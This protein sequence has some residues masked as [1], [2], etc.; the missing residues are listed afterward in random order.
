V[1]KLILLT[2]LVLLAAALSA[3]THALWTGSA[4]TNW[5]NPANWFSNVV[6]TNTSMVNIQADL[7]NYPVISQGPAQCRSL[8]VQNGGQLSLDGANLSVTTTMTVKGN[9]TITSANQIDV[10]GNLTWDDGATVTISHSG[11]VIAARQNVTFLPGS[12][13]KFG[14]GTLR[15]FTST[16]QYK[17]LKNQSAN[18]EF[19]DL[20]MDVRSPAKAVFSS[21]STH[22]FVVNHNFY[23]GTP[24]DSTAECIFWYEGNMILKNDFVSYN[25]ERGVDW[26]Y[27]TLVMEGE[28]DQFIHPTGV[29]GL[30]NLCIRSGGTVEV[31][32]DLIC[33]GNLSI[34]SGVLS[35]GSSTLS[36]WGNWTNYAGFDHFDAGSSTVRFVKHDDSQHHYGN[37]HF[38]VLEIDKAL[39]AFLIYNGGEVIC[40]EY[41]VVRGAVA[42]MDG[43]FTALSLANNGLAGGWYCY[44]NGTIN[45]Y[46]TAPGAWIDLLGYIYMAGGTMNIYGG[47]TPSYWPYAEGA[48]VQIHGGVLD[49]KTQ[50]IHLYSGAY[51][52]T[53][54]TDITG[55]TIRMAGDFTGYHS[56]FSASGATIELYGTEEAQ[57]NILEPMMLPTLKINKT[58]WG[59]RK[60]DLLSD[61]DCENLIVQAGTLGI[62]EQ[63]LT[64][65]NDLTC[66]GNISMGNAGSNGTI[67]VEGNMNFLSGSS[68]QFTSGSAIGRGDFLVENGAIIVFHEGMILHLQG[69]GTHYITVQEDL[70]GFQNLHLG[71]PNRNAH[72]LVSNESTHD[73]FVWGDLN[74]FGTSSLGFEENATQPVKVS[75]TMNMFGGTLNVG[76]SKVIVEGK[77]QFLATSSINI[78]HNGE[79]IFNYHDIP[80]QIEFRG[81]VTIDGGTLRLANSSLYIMENC[82]FNMNSGYVI[83]DGVNAQYAGSFQPTGGTVIMDDNYGNGN[84]GISVINGNWLPN[85]VVD[86]SIGIWLIDDLEVKG[87]IDVN[88]GW[89]E[90]NGLILT[91]RGDLNV[92]NGGL[93]KLEPGTTIDF[94]GSPHSK[95]RIHSGGRL[96]SLGTDAQRITI[97]NSVDWMEYSVLDGG[98][99]AAEYTD[100]RHATMDGFYVH[101]GAIVDEEH[102][103]HNCAFEYSMGLE[104]SCLLRIENDQILTVKNAE[105]NRWPNANNVRKSENQ[106]IVH[107]IDATGYSH[108]EQYEKDPHDR[109]FWSPCLDPDVPDLVILKAEYI[110]QA[111]TEG[112]EVLCV[113]TFS[114]I[115]GA[116]VIDPFYIDLYHNRQTP[117]V[118]GNVGNAFYQI[119]EVPAYSTEQV[120]F[121]VTGYGTGTWNSYVQIDTD[122]DAFESNDYNN[123][124]GPFQMIWLP[125]S[126][127]PVTNLRVNKTQAG[128]YKLEWDFEGVCTRFNIYRSV[129]P[130]FTPSAQ[131]LLVA[132]NYPTTE[133]NL[134]NYFHL[135]DRGFFIVTAERDQREPSNRQNEMGDMPSRRRN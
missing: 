111:A 60:V 133:L 80:R 61:L 115:G 23:N 66:Y 16:G 91:C 13:V 12:N 106:G 36:M 110:P 77:P 105:F 31:T 63:F 11:A 116:D 22:D 94:K 119:Q 83:C 107:F 9:I 67:L 95:L 103:F 79:L 81:N 87:N 47:S 90:T 41:S 50:G 45:A 88:R 42:A 114:N 75:G 124:Y 35:L 33:N 134:N 104:G 73:V 120:V 4:D 34:E 19:Y 7:P 52:D 89:I 56:Q 85:L 102:S 25:P 55:G 131:N 109:I 15:M 96:E 62:T 44:E 21:E 74:F 24:A 20:V 46:N 128:T 99:V 39:G 58:G 29:T 122:D 65:Y 53:F 97:A 17:Y 78:A 118:A 14:N 93:L 117:P 40:D 126:V 3:Q 132:V 59:N 38:N 69:Q 113:V 72:Y 57:I 123:V 30:N 32:D 100:F 130:Y 68:A 37:T 84:V 1:K 64:V 10:R 82:E 8:N 28:G 5:H 49:F 127:E 43:T 86:S 101:D 108:G 48:S 18:T 6:P 54:H 135:G 92:R 51:E 2:A 98:S 125:F 129:D 26:Y 121:Y 70:F 76:P 27:G 112:E 71:G